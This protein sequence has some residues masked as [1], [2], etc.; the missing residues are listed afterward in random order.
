MSY[1]YC[2]QCGYMDEVHQ[3]THRKEVI[4]DYGEHYRLEC[5]KCDGPF[6][7]TPPMVID[8]EPIEPSQDELIV[9]NENALLL[10]ADM[11]M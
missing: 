10:K 3:G 11:E 7:S 6:A 4:H 1:L 2:I 8:L 9:M 5:Q